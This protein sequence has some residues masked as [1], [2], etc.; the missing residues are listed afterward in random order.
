MTSRMSFKLPM[1]SNLQSRAASKPKKSSSS[2][3][4][5][6]PKED[7][8]FSNAPDLFEC[9]RVQAI[10]MV[11]LKAE[12]RAY[13]SWSPDAGFRWGLIDVRKR[14][15]TESQS[16]LTKALRKDRHPLTKNHK[17]CLKN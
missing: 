12:C 10:S 3:S 5:K 15:P 14:V 11:V 16:S 7:F 13:N 1:G 4:A 8:K 2:K 17:T 6:Y 9:I